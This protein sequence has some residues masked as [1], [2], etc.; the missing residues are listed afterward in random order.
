M[1]ESELRD[2]VAEAPAAIPGPRTMDQI[3]H[4]FGHAEGRADEIAK[5]EF[6]RSGT[7]RA[8]QV[9]YYLGKADGLRWAHTGEG[10][11]IDH[12]LKRLLKLLEGGRE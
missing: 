3:Q 7:P 10:R 2:W 4:A 1:T 9:A 5:D 11:S 6:T 8:V 12:H